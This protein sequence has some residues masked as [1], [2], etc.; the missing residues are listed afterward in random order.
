MKRDSEQ[1]RK[2]LRWMAGKARRGHSG[3]NEAQELGLHFSWT[4]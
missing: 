3:W 4:A 1:G 2:V